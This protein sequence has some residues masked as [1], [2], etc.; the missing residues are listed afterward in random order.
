MPLSQQL[1]TV[2]NVKLDPGMLPDGD[3]PLVGKIAELIRGLILAEQFAPGDELPSSRTIATDLRCGLDTVQ[4][5]MTLLKGEGL[6]VGGKGRV[7]RVRVRPPVRH[8]SA[9]RY[10]RELDTLHRGQA[11]ESAFCTDYGIPWDLYVV[12]AAVVTR[13]AGA[14]VAHHTGW[15]EAEQ[16][17]RRRMVEYADGVP[18]Q[19]RT[20]IV[21]AWLS[22]R[23]PQLADHRVH[24]V[25][26]GIL[27]ELHGAGVAPV[28]WREWFTVRQPTSTEARELDIDT[29]TPVYQWMRMFWHDD[30]EVIEISETIIPCHALIPQQEGQLP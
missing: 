21:P 2:S 12:D 19:I 10:A 20:S 1:D 26:G 9:D 28:R 6:V 25:R 22:R 24:P 18:V 30:G 7:Y 16:V 8:L 14:F 3:R 13:A 17:T 4:D 29:G 15:R 27:A 23:E 11:P 5:A